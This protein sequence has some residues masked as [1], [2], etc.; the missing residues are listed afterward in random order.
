[1]VLIEAEVKKKQRKWRL[2]RS[3]DSFIFHINITSTNFQM[4]VFWILYS[5]VQTWFSPSHDVPCVTFIHP[6]RDAA[7]PSL[8]VHSSINAHPFIS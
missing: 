7:H 6:S 2:S 5:A 3:P 4:S 8:D 1:M